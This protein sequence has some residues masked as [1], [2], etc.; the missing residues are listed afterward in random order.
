MIKL[1]LC[2]SANIGTG[3]TCKPLQVAYVNESKDEQIPEAFHISRAH[4]WE[5]FRVYLNNASD[6]QT[7]SL[8]Q[9]EKLTQM[10][11]SYFSSATAHNHRWL[12]DID[13]ANM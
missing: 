8:T 4:K 12:I 6:S 7:Q 3:T 5:N 10:L 13:N 11:G 1:I 2:K 9:T